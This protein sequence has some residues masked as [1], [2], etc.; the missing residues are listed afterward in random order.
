MDFMAERGGR[1]ARPVYGQGFR[2]G[3]LIKFYSHSL[4]WLV[5]HVGLVDVATEFLEDGEPLIYGELS[6]DEL[7]RL[8]AEGRLRHI[9]RHFW[10]ISWPYDGQHDQ[11]AADGEAF[12]DYDLWRGRLLAAAREA[13]ALSSSPAAVAH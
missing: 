6:Y 4:Y 13:A 9:R 1:G 3:N 7:D 8:E 11:P 2:S 12:S 5:R 10:G